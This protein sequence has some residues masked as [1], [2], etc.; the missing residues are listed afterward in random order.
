MLLKAFCFR[1]LSAILCLAAE[2]SR[3]P[4]GVAGLLKSTESKWHVG[5]MGLTRTLEESGLTGLEEVS[6]GTWKMEAG[7]L[8]CFYLLC[9]WGTVLS[10]MAIDWFCHHNIH[11]Q[12]R[13]IMSKS[14]FSS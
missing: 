7:K 9:H 3:Q 5:E 11:T 6:E 12:I 4:S 14:E 8:I 2:V 10:Q 13:N 1:G